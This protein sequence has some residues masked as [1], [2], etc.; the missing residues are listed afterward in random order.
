MWW[1]DRA[2]VEKIERFSAPWSIGTRS[3]QQTDN[4]SVPENYEASKQTDTI[5]LRFASYHNI[6]ALCANMWQ[7]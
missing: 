6:Q 1:K 4:E 3:S 7:F 5:K 2:T